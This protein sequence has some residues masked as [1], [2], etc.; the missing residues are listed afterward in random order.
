[1]ST[2]P[3]QVVLTEEE[4]SG[5]KL[6]YDN[7]SNFL[8][9]KTIPGNLWERIC[10]RQFPKEGRQE[11]EAW[12]EMFERCTTARQKKLNFLSEKLNNSY[13]NVSR[14]FWRFLATNRLVTLVQYF[15]FC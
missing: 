9:Q 6:A 13:K 11:F 1:M 15:I 5:D 4:L 2:C 10:K 8:N 7:S 12:R 3:R 14:S